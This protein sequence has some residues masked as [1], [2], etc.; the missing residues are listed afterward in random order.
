MIQKW[1]FVLSF[2]LLC[3]QILEVKSMNVNV[4]KSDPLLFDFD[5]AIGS[6]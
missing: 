2:L 6:D 5:A 3:F 1:G 4:P